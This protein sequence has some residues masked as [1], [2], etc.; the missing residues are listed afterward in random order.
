MNPGEKFEYKYLIQGGGTFK[1]A[2]AL[3]SGNRSAVPVG[4]SYLIVDT[5]MKISIQI[6]LM[7]V[8]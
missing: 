1:P 4:S 5:R 3:P 2:E 6:A 8:F 7:I